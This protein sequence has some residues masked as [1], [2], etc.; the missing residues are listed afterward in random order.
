MIEERQAERNLLRVYPR[1]RRRGEST[2]SS[3][4]V[5]AVLN[6][7]GRRLEVAMP[8]RIR[9]IR[10]RQY[11]KRRRV[12]GGLVDRIL[13]RGFE[14]DKEEGPSGAYGAASFQCRGRFSGPVKIFRR[15][16]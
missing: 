11:G 4:Y 10:F 8:K 16:V 5:V 13:H 15:D 7:I 3:K 2:L 12:L 14:S 6:S 9:T 1:R